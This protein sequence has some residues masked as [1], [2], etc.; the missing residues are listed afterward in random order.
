M[1]FPLY[2]VCIVHEEFLNKFITNQYKDMLDSL[3][4]YNSGE[5]FFIMYYKCPYN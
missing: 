3:H 4:F 5:F 1:A 2:R